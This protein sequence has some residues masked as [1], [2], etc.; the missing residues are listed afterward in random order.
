MRTTIVQVSGKASGLSGGQCR[1]SR[2]APAGTATDRYRQTGRQFL[3]FEARPGRIGVAVDDPDQVRPVRLG[4]LAG[5]LDG[6]PLA[7]SRREPVDIADQGN[8]HS[9]LRCRR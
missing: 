9:S 1:R 5:H 7:R 8:H 3:E 6:N 2:H 4:E